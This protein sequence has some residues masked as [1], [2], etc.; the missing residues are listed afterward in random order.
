M[1]DISDAPW[2]GRGDTGL[3]ALERVQR[4]LTVDMIMTPRDRLKTC[5]PDDSAREVMDRN[6]ERYSYLPVVDE[7]SRILGLYQ[8]DRWFEEEAPDQPIGDDFEPF[9]EVLVIGANASIIDFVKA[10]DDRPTRLVVS[11]RRVAGLISLSDLQQLPIRAA[12]FTLITSLELAMAKRIESE[13]WPDGAASW[14]ALLS[15]ARRNK[16]L[17]AIDKAKQGEIFVNEISLTQFSDKGTIIRKQ[18][19]IPGS[20][21]KLLRDFSAIRKLRDLIAH[22]NYYAETPTEAQKVCSA[23]GTILDIQS[24]LHKETVQTGES[25][26]TKA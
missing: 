8:A 17:Q 2:A 14:L 15:E 22:S 5:Q 4:G 18:G 7:N 6:I 11:G 9:S 26:S 3:D 12:L 19:L 13:E 23:V 16:I 21:S 25:T 20:K 10:A 1:A 24:L